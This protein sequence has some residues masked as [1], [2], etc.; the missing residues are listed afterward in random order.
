M[1]DSGLDDDFSPEPRG[2]CYT[3]P[4][5]Q[6]V[7]PPD[8]QHHH[9]HQNQQ[10]QQQQHQA[11]YP[12]MHHHAAAHHQHHPYGAPPTHLNLTALTSSGSSVASSIGG[13]ANCNGSP[14][15][16]QPPALPGAASGSSS[17]SSCSSATTTV[18]QMLAAASVPS[19]SSTATTTMTLGMSLSLSAGGG[20]MMPAKK[21]RC[22]KK[23][24]DQ[25]AQKKPNPWGEESYSDII[26]KA[27]ESAPDGRL[28]LNEIYQWFSDNIPYF[29]ERSSQEEAAG[30]KNSIRHNLSLHSRF[31]R[32][33][34]EGAGKSSWW[35]INPEAKPGRNPR[36]TRERSNTIESTTKVQLEK[37]RR[38]AKKRLSQKAAS[39]LMGSVH[40]GG[41]NGSSNAGSLQSIQHDMFADDD[42]MQGSFE[43]M[44]TF[45]P[46]TQ[47]N[48]SVPGSSSRVSPAVDPMYDEMDF[49]NWVSEQTNVAIP[50]DI[51]DRTDQMRIDGNHSMN[52]TPIKQ[53]SKPIKTEPIAPPPSYHELNTV[54]GP[55]AQNPLFRNPIVPS[56]NFK[57]MPL[58][59][60]YNTYENG[61]GGWL[62][63]SMAPPLP[64][65]SCGAVAAQHQVSSSSALPIDLENLTL[66]DQPL[67]DMDVDALIRHE[68]AQAGGH[69]INFDL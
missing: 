17:S 69:Q 61:N 19:C 56:T 40:S 28:K 29:R 27:L 1:N 4:M 3:W 36:R 15:A 7:Y 16:S 43:T 14:G 9:H 54:R 24:T 8:Q 58:P 35:V 42:S 20:P 65:I 18:G 47:S 49:P 26:A 45:R 10:Y 39:G 37:T 2:R 11:H 68:M 46:R 13:G 5:Q 23:P 55:C 6:F 12:Y 30:W 31:M 44:P 52:G 41:L 57:P 34:N 62:T 51:V 60:A 25:L 67:M 64:G 66:P 63:T 59:S 32:I 50:S 22:R 33:Q 48:L 38:G 21:K 53:E